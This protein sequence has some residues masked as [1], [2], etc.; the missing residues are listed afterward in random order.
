MLCKRFLIQIKEQIYWS[1][2]LSFDN[3]KETNEISINSNNFNT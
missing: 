2:K 3:Q 1:N